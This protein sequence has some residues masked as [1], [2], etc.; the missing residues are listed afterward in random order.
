[1]EES[2]VVQQQLELVADPAYFPPE[3]CDLYLVW[4]CFSIEPH[5]RSI[6]E[7]PR[8]WMSGSLGS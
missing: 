4:R 1:M 7:S 6:V 5:I 3:F 8:R 2:Q